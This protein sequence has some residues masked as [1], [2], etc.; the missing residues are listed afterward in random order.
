M[1]DASD[2]LVEIQ[3]LIK[4]YGSLRPVRIQSF[5][6]RRG[7]RLTLIGLDQA[8]AEMFVT[9]I[10][11]AA[12]PDEGTVRLFGQLTSEIPSGDEWLTLLDRL[13]MLSDRA[14]LVEQYSVAQNIAMPFT[15]ELEPIPSELLPRIVDL[16]REVGLDESVRDTPVGT[17]A[18]QVRARVR[19]AR[20]IALEPVLVLAEHPSA[21]LPRDAVS[22]FAKD[23]ARVAEARQIGLVTISADKDF[24][25]AF[26]G[27]TLIVEGA[28]GEVRK[29]RFW[30]KL[31]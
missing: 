14:V 10:T 15:L 25:R 16:M 26:D 6:V 30:E 7:D 24:V 18:P 13:G 8:A 19:L 22:A 1:A 28:T 21:S 4:N 5:S 23:L 2:V 17:V 11:G 20:A 27:T 9:L 29:Q 12:L 31:R 3:G